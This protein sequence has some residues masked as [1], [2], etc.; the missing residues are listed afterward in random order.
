[1][2][3]LPT[4]VLRRPNRRMLPAHHRLATD[5]AGAAMANEGIVGFPLFH[6]QRFESATSLVTLLAFREEFSQ[7]GLEILVR[8]H[9]DLAKLNAYHAKIVHRGR[10]LPAFVSQG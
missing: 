8:R 3:A 1:I 2:P 9:C 6:A 7:A 4:T 10:M 5:A